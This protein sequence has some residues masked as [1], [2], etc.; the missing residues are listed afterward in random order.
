MVGNSQ[1]VGGRDSKSAKCDQGFNVMGSIE[2]YVRCP[3][4]SGRFDTGVDKI[5]YY[6]SAC[7][8]YEEFNFT[9]LPSLTKAVYV[10]FA[11][12]VPILL[13]NM[14]IAMMANTYQQIIRRAEKQWKRQVPSLS[15]HVSV[16]CYKLN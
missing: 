14:L 16:V 10:A 1:V 8:Q 2:H 3:P 15:S 5:T 4:P 12:F 7:L 6:T 13:L 11:V 9:R